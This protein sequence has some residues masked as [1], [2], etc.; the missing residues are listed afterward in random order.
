MSAQMLANK[1][2][3]IVRH[4]TRVLRKPPGAFAA[5]DAENYDVHFG[6]AG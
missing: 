2:L 4:D 6:V 3:C 5:S 1:V